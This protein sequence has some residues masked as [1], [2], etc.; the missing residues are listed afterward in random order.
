[1]R[2]PRH[3]VRSLTLTTAVAV[4]SLAGVAPSTGAVHQ[5]PSPPHAAKPPADPT[6]VVAVAGPGQSFGGPAVLTTSTRVSLMSYYRQ[7]PGVAR[8][9]ELQRQS[10]ASDW[11]PVALPQGGLDTFGSPSLV[12]DPA[13][14]RILLTASADASGDLAGTLGTYLWWSADQ[15]VTWSAPIRVWNSFGVGDAAPDGT[16]G[17]WTTVGQTDALIAHVPAGY[18][19]QT[20]PSGAVRLTD[21]LGSRGA[22]GLVTAG[23]ARTPVFGFYSTSGVYAHRGATYD[24]GLDTQVFG[25]GSLGSLL[26]VAGDS[27]G[28][29]LATSHTPGYAASGTSALW[30]RSLDPT[31]GALSDERRLSTG[32]ALFFQ[33]RAL[34]SGR[35]PAAI[36]RDNG[37]S[38]LYVARASGGVDG[39]WSTSTVIDDE[40]DAVS[41]YAYLDVSDGWAV[42]LGN[43]DSDS[44]AVVW[45]ADAS[46]RT[47]D[48]TLARKGRASYSAKSGTL[49]IRTT[50]NTPGRI[51]TVATV[52]A[53]GRK[54]T[55]VARAVR[56]TGYGT[57][58][59][60]VKVPKAARAL[61]RSV[62]KARVTLSVTF[63]NSA[64]KARLRAAVKA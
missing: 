58:T 49:A 60:K 57:Y 38:D 56:S 41:Y 47:V 48:P 15:G 9:L 52:T 5:D 39:T 27:S 36:W 62:P 59:T 33:L 20:T 45:A 32:Q 24:P 21:K 22:T 23:A 61:L 3:L 11:T 42:G 44:A 35:G 51:K 29:A 64:G 63:V 16:G 53:P 19:M 1:M 17:F 13:T 8:V 18:A 14:G 7:G 37:D 2:A 25:A 10:G 55:K 6:T 50:V 28:A 26:G 12:Q 46:P 31:T 40:A 54:P 34:P 4:A 30:V 43:R